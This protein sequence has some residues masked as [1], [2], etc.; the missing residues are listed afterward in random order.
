MQCLLHIS[1]TFPNIKI[2]PLKF[3]PVQT[4]DGTIPIPK[5]EWEST[6]FCTGVIELES[7]FISNLSAG[8]GIGIEIDVIRNW[9]R[10]DHT[11]NRNQR[12]AFG[13]ESELELD[14]SQ[15]NDN[16]NQRY[17][18]HA[19]IGRNM[20]WARQNQFLALIFF[21]M[22]HKHKDVPHGGQ[23]DTEVIHIDAAGRTTEAQP[24]SRQTE[25]HTFRFQI[26]LTV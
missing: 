6:V 3:I 21:I 4:S 15:W 7:E 18:N 26:S 13:L 8:I 14:W 12:K 24:K 5:S 9:D 16:G 22:C 19:D 20:Q 25:S 2:W 23:Q 10:I 17:L 11:W 1:T